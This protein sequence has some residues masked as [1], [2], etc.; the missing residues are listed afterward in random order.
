[1]TSKWGKP[2][3]QE[4]KIVL[5]SVPAWRGVLATKTQNITPSLPSPPTNWQDRETRVETTLTWLNVCV[6]CRKSLSRTSRLDSL[7]LL[8]NLE[9]R[10]IR[11][12][13]CEKNK[14]LFD[15]KYTGRPPSGGLFLLGAE[16]W[17]SFFFFAAL[18]VIVPPLFSSLTTRLGRCLRSSKYDR[19]PLTTPPPPKKTPDYVIR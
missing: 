14:L 8:P 4:E 16:V 5:T 17:F 13:G 7:G 6:S 18:R 3:L 12:G 1:M 15:L 9:Y 11:S 19:R 2:F 10:K